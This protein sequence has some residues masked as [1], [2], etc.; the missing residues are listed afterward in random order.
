MKKFILILT[1]LV[2]CLYAQDQVFGLKFMSSLGEVKTKVPSLKMNTKS[3]GGKIVSYLTE[4]VPVSHSDAESYALIFYKDKYLI[5]TLMICKN[6]EGD[7]YG[8]EGVELF[9]KLL[10]QLE[11]KYT[12]KDS[13][14]LIGNKLYNESDEFWQCLKYEGCG[15]FAALLKN[16]K[17]T[18]AGVKLKGVSRG[19]GY[20][21]VEFEA[22][23][24]KLYLDSAKTYANKKDTQA[25]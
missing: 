21:V 25:F 12:L 16:E 15:F 6:I 13:Y 19:K 5:K 10:K 24:F 20:A 17:G 1:A 14:R 23:Q 18:T 2:I 7:P 3:H 8:I 22:P 9:D 11:S 4:T